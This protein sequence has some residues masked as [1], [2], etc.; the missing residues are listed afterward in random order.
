MLPQQSKRS[1][2]GHPSPACSF[3]SQ[4]FLY[5]FSPSVRFL[6]SVFSQFSEWVVL[7]LVIATAFTEALCFLVY[8]SPVVSIPLKEALPLDLRAHQYRLCILVKESLFYVQK[9]H[10]LFLFFILSTFRWRRFRIP[11]QVHRFR[12]NHCARDIS[13]SSERCSLCSL[14]SYLQLGKW[15]LGPWEPSLGNKFPGFDH[16]L[17]PFALMRLGAERFWDNDCAGLFVGTS[18][19]KDETL[20]GRVTLLLSGEEEFKFHNINLL[21]WRP[22]RKAV[23]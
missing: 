19:F 14:S 6:G 5:F 3:T 10:F 9:F 21:M 7:W 13:S 15:G 20:P 23:D 22:S 11:L 4:V 2:Q 18:L 1:C 17:M 8:I 16:G 12:V